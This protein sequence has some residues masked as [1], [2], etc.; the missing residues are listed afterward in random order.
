METTHK[1]ELSASLEKAFSNFFLLLNEFDERE[2]NTVPFESSWTAAQVADH[3]TRSNR[4]IAKALLLKGTIINRNPFGR[5]QELKNIFLDFST[6]LKSPD[7]IL[8]GKNL[9]DK[10]EL[11][12]NLLD[13]IRK[14]KEAF[15]HA[16]LLEM[17]NHQAFGDITKFEI[18][19]FVVYHTQRHTHQLEN[20]LRSVK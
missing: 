16:E 7:F 4:S 12:G 3:V 14:I 11:T 8:P 18:L 13:S 6:K 9:Y 15:N 17:I 19:H 20:I 5:V 10:K 1:E 2:I